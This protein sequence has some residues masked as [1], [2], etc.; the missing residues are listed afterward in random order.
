MDGRL[1]VTSKEG[2]GSTFVVELP[3]AIAPT[4]EESAPVVQHA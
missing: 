4:A 1:T 2:E 3:L